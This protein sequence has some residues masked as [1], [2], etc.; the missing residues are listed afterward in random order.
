MSTYKTVIDPQVAGI[1]ITMSQSFPA[2]GGA[3][4]TQAVTS[5]AADVYAVVIDNSLNTSASYLKCYDATGTPG[6]GSSQPFMILKSD[7][8]TKVQYSFDKG[9]AF[10]SGI[11]AAVLTS[12]G[13]AGTTA[14]SSEVNLTFLVTAT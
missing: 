9:V 14:P 13:T 11:A 12:K 5:Y 2:G 4:A 10:S 1:A 3:L 6:I 8:A 7:A